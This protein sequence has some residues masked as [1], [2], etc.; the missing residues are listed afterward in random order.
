MR[1]ARPRSFR[2][3]LAVNLLVTVL[4]FALVTAGATYAAVRLSAQRASQAMMAQVVDT[5]A[6]ETS[7]FYRSVASIFTLV[8]FWAARTWSGAWDTYEFDRIFA[9]MLLAFYEASSVYLAQGSG[10]FYMLSRD[11]ATWLSW[12]VRPVAWGDRALLRTWTDDD[13]IPKE[14]WRPLEF[15]VRTLPWFE[16]ALVRI[17]AVGASA[18]LADRTTVGRAALSPATR[19]PGQALTMAGA[20][21]LDDR[22]VFAFERSLTGVTER[23]A[24]LRV[25]EGGR[26]A[27]LT[28]DPSAPGEL[29]LT[30]VPIS[31]AA[32]DLAAAERLILAPPERLGGPVAA[33]VAGSVTDR[34]TLPSEPVRFTSDGIA[35]WGMARRVD[36]SGFERSAQPDWVVAV[37]PEQ[38]LLRRLPNLGLA[39]A[40][41][42]ALAL[43]LAF[44]RARALAGR[45]S[46][47]IDELVEHSRRM[48]RLDFERPARVDTDI[49]EIGILGGTLESMRRALHA[50]ASIS[51][52]TRI[53]EAILRGTL[54]AGLRRPD[55]YAIEA[56]WQPAAESGGEV[57]DVLVEEPG[58]ATAGRA[59]LLLLE[60]DS[61]G[62]EAA[63]LSAQLRA[64]F[65]SA[66]RSG[67]GPG[68]IAAYLQRCLVEDL[69]EAGTVR[70]WI[71]LLDPPSGRLDWVAAGF[72]GN[73][74]H[75]GAAGTAADLLDSA[76]PALGA[77]RGHGFR[78]SALVLAE[79]ELLAVVSDGVIDALSD[80]R[81]RFG[82]G[83]VRDTLLRHAA[84][85]PA[86][87]A[88]EIER[89]IAAFTGQARVQADRTVLLLARTRPDP[90]A[91]RG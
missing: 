23:L 64:V 26:V 71:G 15:D 7:T 40:A 18:P 68:E 29:I 50:Y 79:G 84:A 34:R 10:D 52:E 45:F 87:I 80:A 86:A 46:Q 17:E 14:T 56:L 37:V 81:E 22:F 66:V 67:A 65:R 5:V 49:V 9:P 85:D 30:G 58:A 19:V 60:P 42:T 3:S 12:T 75:L 83:R 89:A 41:V 62:V 6:A 27:T 16:A 44:L 25:L 28:G 21:P 31:G 91:T 73:V 54:P 61:F 13:P 33:F 57:F 70:A 32:H 8:D 53:A 38:D 90:P 36:A 82:I 55:G 35:W 4:L 69:R 78:C 11:D 76:E 72:T 2:R 51:E 1:W 47:P 24:E 48:Q 74:V 59:A 43:A 77:E 88:G 63:V 20:T 39:L